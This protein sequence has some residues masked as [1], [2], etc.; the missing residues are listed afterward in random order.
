MFFIV[1]QTGMGARQAGAI[2]VPVW[3]IK[4]H[5]GAIRSHRPVKSC[6]QKLD[7]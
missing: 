5:L 4:S 7:D 6:I 3:L 2:K 1:C